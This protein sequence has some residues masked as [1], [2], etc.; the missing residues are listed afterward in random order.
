MKNI[1]LSL[2]LVLPAAAADTVKAPA[3]S[4]S[5]TAIQVVFPNPPDKPRVRFVRSIKNMRDL[6][7]RKE[8]FFEKLF[9]FLAGGDVTL[10]FFSGAYGVYLQGNKLYVS[11]TGAQHLAVLDLVKF[12][13]SYIGDKGEEN[14]RSPIGVVADP[15]GTV[16]VT[17][18][19]DHSVKAYSA[20][21]KL[22]WKTDVLGTGG[23][24]FNRPSGLSPTPDGNLL[25]ADNG[26]RRLVLISK[27]GKFIKELCANAKKEPLALANPNN[28]WV[29]KD[30]SFVVSDPLAARVHVFT[31]TGGFIGGFGEP[32]DSPGYLARPRGVAVDSD[33]NIHVV[34]AVFSRVQIFDRAGQLLLWYATPGSREAQLALPAGIFIDKDDTIY[35]A[36]T[37]NQRIQVFQYIKYPQ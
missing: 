13:M 32:G 19:G 26:N 8:N 18:T 20:A 25:V 12:S 24:K 11:D 29:D 10:P 28:V 34:D 9:S 30:G 15:D 22:I 17:D 33:G 4:A 3:V 6:K 1:I 35:I 36:D 14:L 7:G 37:K 31:S 16:Y 21:G 5:T 27:Q 2:A 23:D